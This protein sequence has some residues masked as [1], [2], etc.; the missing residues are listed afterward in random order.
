MYNRTLGLCREYNLNM[1]HDI[2]KMIEEMIPSDGLLYASQFK[3][4]LY[5]ETSALLG[6]NIDI[7]VRAITTKCIELDDLGKK[8]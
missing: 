2:I 7:A 1:P 4:M 6:A 5:Y 8:S 3:N